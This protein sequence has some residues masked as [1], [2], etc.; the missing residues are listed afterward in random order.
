MSKPDTSSNPSFEQQS[1]ESAG[2]GAYDGSG[3]YPTSEFRYASVWSRFWAFVIDGIV[4]SV[5]G[6]IFNLVLPVAGGLVAWFFYAPILEASTVRGTVGKRFLGLHVVDR[7]GE[8]I[9]FKASLVR[10]I[11]K[12]VSSILLCLGFI[13][14]LFSSQKQTV[15]DLLADTLVVYAAPRSHEVGVLA[16]WWARVRELFK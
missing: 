6:V 2:Q 12:T 4:L 14:A 7:Q 16:G 1:A 8:R 13:T 9:S 5:V 11:L 3:S 15:H 10:N